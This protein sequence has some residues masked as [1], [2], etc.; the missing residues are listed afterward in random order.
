VASALGVMVGVSGLDQGFFEMLRGNAATGSL[1]VKAIGPDQ[2]MWAHGTEEAL[3]IVPTFLAAGILA[4][5]IAVALIVWS[6]RFIG[7]PDGGGVFLALAGLLFLA[8]GGVAM[9]VFVVFGWAVARRIGRPITWWR[10]L[11]AVIAGLAARGWRP[12]IA[13]CALLYAFALE[14]AIAGVVP[15]VA[16][17]ELRLYICWSALLAMMAG[18]VLALIGAS[19]GDA[20]DETSAAAAP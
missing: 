11:P 20:S 7:R 3:T 17:P 2:R 15:G 10:A 18:M 1:I 14:I 19:A 8:G 4:V 5:A 6:V 12:L 16:D 13:A 9:I